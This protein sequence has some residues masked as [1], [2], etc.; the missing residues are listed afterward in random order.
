MIHASPPALD[1]TLHPTLTYT[2]SN[3]KL[4]S[5]TSLIEALRGGGVDYRLIEP[6]DPHVRV[7][8][9]SAV[10]TA[11]VKMEVEAAGQLH[12]LEMFYT[13]V[14]FLEAGVWQLAAYQSVGV[15]P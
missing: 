6:I 10:L 1:A 13:A 4:D 7:R 15:S 8:G 12:Q 11:R 14:Y 9:E 3:G 2:H 5:K